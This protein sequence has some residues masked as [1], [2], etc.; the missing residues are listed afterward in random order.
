[1]RIG[2]LSCV[3]VSH[4]ACVA[5]LGL[6]PL[7]ASAASSGLALTTNEND[8]TNSFLVTTCNATAANAIF[9]QG[10]FA[11]SGVVNDSGVAITTLLTGAASDG[12][13]P[14]QVTGSANYIGSHANA[15]INFTGQLK[16]DSATTGHVTSI[17]AML[18]VADGTSSVKTYKLNPNMRTA[19]LTLNF[20][21]QTVAMALDGTPE[22][23]N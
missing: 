18:V 23:I 15:F 2:Q 11:L 17:V 6:L 20:A 16:C 8:P 10:T 19:T 7:S 22:R 4:C 3:A 1:M 12:P 9:T 5:T 14:N 13:A 21:A